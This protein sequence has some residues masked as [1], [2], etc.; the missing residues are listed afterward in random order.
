MRG[1]C[2]V[3]RGRRWRRR[4]RRLALSPEDIR[5]RLGGHRR[6]RMASLFQVLQ[7]LVGEKLLYVLLG[8]QARNF[9]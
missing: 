5:C 3:T 4:R 1:I 8:V 9:P 2:G 7:V 6:G